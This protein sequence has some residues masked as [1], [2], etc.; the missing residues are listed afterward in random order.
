MRK[1]A[2]F[3]LMILV[4]ISCGKKQAKVT[5]IDINKFEEQ[6]ATLVDQ[7]VSM[8]GMV[9][10]IC[11]HG[12]KK[13]FLVGDNPDN[14]IVVFAGEQISEFPVELEG[15]KVKVF[16]IIKEEIITEDTI[17]QWEAED[18]ANDT[19]NKSIEVNAGNAQPVDAK[20]VKEGK[21][22]NVAVKDTAKSEC[23]DE[24]AEHK[25]GK[26]ED[27]RYAAI[28]QKIAESKDGKYRRYW[29]EVTKF[30]EVKE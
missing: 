10:H 7:Q 27:D 12:G 18:A 15:K 2:L 26:C 3:S 19:A 24:S 9:V 23:I 1:T 30:E 14:K 16:G 13:M 8:T 6:A 28:R 25:E 20:A 29:I 11:K 17:R 4:M 22:E 21:V 5:E